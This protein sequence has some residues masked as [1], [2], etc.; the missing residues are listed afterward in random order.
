MPIVEGQLCDCAVLTSN[1]P[2]MTE[3]GLDSVLYVDPTS[4][5]SIRVGFKMLIE[6]KQLRQQLIE[7][8]RINAK[9][10][11]PEIISNCYLELYKTL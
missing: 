4:I 5:D 6:N 7:K 2:P 8:G 10:F 9:R 1:I 11:S 3:V